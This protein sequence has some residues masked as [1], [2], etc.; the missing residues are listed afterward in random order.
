MR[1]L[2]LWFCMIVFCLTLFNVVAIAQDDTMQGPP[3][4]LMLIREQVKPGRA[5]AHTMN[6][7]AWTAGVKQAHYDTAALGMNSVT[8]ES[9]SWFLI[10]YPSFEAMEKDGEKMDKD[11]TIRHVNETYG[12]KEADLISDSRTMT[13][14]YRPEM[15]YQPNV[16]VGEYKYF[17]VAIVRFRLGEDVGAFFKALDGAREKANVDTHSAVYSVT[18]GAPSG[19][20]ITFTPMKSMAKMDEPPNEALAAAQKE[21]GWSDMVSKA[22]MNVEFRLFAFSPRMS[23]PSKEMI[24]ADPGYWNPKPMMAKKAAPAEGEK[25]VPAAKKEMKK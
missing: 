5:A 20:Y 3:K 1:K 22:I 4:V 9:E 8:G 10:G 14:R 24:A 13:L 21:M 18:S 17:S 25:P 16:N 11:A 2:V 12:P 6:E 15:S 7:A 23:I 19:T